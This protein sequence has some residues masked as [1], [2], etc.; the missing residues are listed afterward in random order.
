MLKTLAISLLALSSTAV[1]AGSAHACG[2]KCCAGSAPAAACCDVAAPAATAVPATGYRTYSYEPGS[3]VAPRMRRSY[4]V[5]YGTP[6][7]FRDAG[8]KIRGY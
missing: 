3:Y 5:P 6:N 1:A 8:G 7:V 2:G 4:G